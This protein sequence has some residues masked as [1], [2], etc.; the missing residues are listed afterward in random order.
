MIR[1]ARRIAEERRD[2]RLPCLLEIEYASSRH[3]PLGPALN[4][5][6]S[7]VLERLVRPERVEQLDLCRDLDDRM[8]ADIFLGCHARV[9]GML[10]AIPPFDGGGGRVLEDRDR[11]AGE[12]VAAEDALAD[13][14][15]LVM[16]SV[17]IGDVN[18]VKAP[19]ESREL[20]RRA[21]D[22]QPSVLASHP[23]ARVACRNEELGLRR[24]DALRPA[25]HEPEDEERQ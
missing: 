20:E 21:A 11:I 14:E 15:R 2:G 10:V 23:E 19:L 22:L 12:E 24:G 17:V 8:L 1:R 3:V 18:L 7:V 16:R 6:V 13:D 5:A 9:G 25:G 4:R